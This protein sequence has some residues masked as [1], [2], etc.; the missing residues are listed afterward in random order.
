M[1]NVFNRFYQDY[2]AWY[3]T[4][5]GAF[6]DQVETDALWSL[7][8]PNPG[9][10]ILDVGCG[11][12]L[13]SLKLARHGCEVTGIDIAPNMLHEA[14]RKSGE[15]GLSIDFRR[16]DCQQMEFPDNSFDAAI[17]MAA[18]EFIPDPLRAYRE[19]RRVV[20]PGGLIV[21]GIIQR[22]GDWASLYASDICKGTAYEYATFRSLEDLRALD[23]QGFD[24]ALECL[25]VPPG[26]P[27]EAYT[28]DTEQ[29]LAAAGKKGG[30]LCVR[31]K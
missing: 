19:M 6:V 23:T 1:E 30:F 8:A 10:R 7:L 28:A 25:F 26:E 15:E 31:F 20:K 24:R 14:V 3:Q 18:F 9:M 21:I 27:D 17:S 2:D 13:Q 29:T 4:P 22:E 16:M 5:M 11:T 12:G